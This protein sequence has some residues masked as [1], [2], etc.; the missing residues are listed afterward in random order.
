LLPGLGTVLAESLLA[1]L[2]ASPPD[3]DREVVPMRISQLLLAF[4]VLLACPA[5]AGMVTYDIGPYRAGGFAASYLH[6]SDG[7]TGRGQLDLDANGR[8]D[9]L[10]MC[11]NRTQ[12]VTGQITG[13]W[14]GRKLTDISGSI[15]GYQV[16]GGRLGGAYDRN[17]GD[18]RLPRWNLRLEGLGLFV[19]ERMPINRINGRQLTLWGQNLAAYLCNTRHCRNRHAVGMD[20]YGSARAALPEPGSIGVMLAGMLGFALALH[21]RR[22]AAELLPTR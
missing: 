18:Y 13:H 7:C 19:F 16:T 14:D 11:G 8:S 2:F 4:L 3:A 10:Y 22:R 5:F 20:L 9:R 17:I 1:G 15:A 21:Q 12:A 6:S